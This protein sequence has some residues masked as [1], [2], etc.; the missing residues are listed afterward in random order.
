MDY[1]SELYW[2][3]PLSL[4]SFVIGLL[5]IFWFYRKGFFDKWGRFD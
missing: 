4:L 2:M 1:Y 3:L 5:L